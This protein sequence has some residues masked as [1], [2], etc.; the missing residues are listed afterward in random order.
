MPKKIEGRP[1]PALRMRLKNFRLFA[2]TGWFRLAPLTFLV[3]RNS[4]GK[5]SIISSLLLLKQSIEQEAVSSSVTPLTLSGPYCDLGT[6][7]DVVHQH[8]EGSDLSLSFSLDLRDLAPLPEELPPFVGIAV[9]RVPAVGRYFSYYPFHDTKLPRAGAMEVGLTFSTDEPFGPS[10]SRIEV[11]IAGVG[12]ARFV[13]TTSGERKQH[14]RVY[15]T[16]LPPQS[17]ALRLLVR[18]FFPVIEIRSSAF[19][20]AA[21]PVRHKI[22]LFVAA[23]QGFFR[24]LSRVLMRNEVIGPFRTPPERRYAFAGFSTSRTGPSGERAVDLLITEALL[25]DERAK[26]LHEAVS[27]W[28]RHLTLARSLDVRDIARRLNL[29]EV[30]VSGA[31]KGTKANL[32][33]VGFGISQVLP[34]IVQGLLTRPGG[35]YLVQQP[36]M[37]LHPDAQAGLADFFIYLASYGVITV[38]ETHS[39]YL[40]L[41]LRRRL[42]EGGLPKRVGLPIENHKVQPLTRRDVAVLLTSTARGR[43]AS[44]SELAIDE[45]FQ[46]ENLPPGFMSQSLE[47]RILL[48][49]L[50]GKRDE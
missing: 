1:R 35:L 25:R 41:R 6:Y 17:L 32:V 48:L 16:D 47:D 14:W 33:D 24:Y 18:A 30:D 28:M 19:K 2:D 50:L 29:F 3:G 4:S 36:E 9:P 26:P 13:R 23:C 20:R 44:V 15:T 46:F 12:S 31:G 11:S 7:R 42:A 22:R 10:L 45:S 43:G 21:P 37:H 27:F 8:N 34:V 39:E 40:L 49:G 38:V 5:S